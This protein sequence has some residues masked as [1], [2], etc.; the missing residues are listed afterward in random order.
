MGGASADDSVKQ[1]WMQAAGGAG[2]ST[3]PQRTIDAEDVCGIC[4]EEM[5]EA[6][7]LKWCQSCGKSLHTMCLKKVSPLPSFPPPAPPHTRAS[8][9]VPSLV[10]C[11][12]DICFFSPPKYR[13]YK[14]N[15]VPLS[16]PYCR[17]PFEKVKAEGGVLNLAA[18]S[19]AHRGGVDLADLY[20]DTHG[21]I[22]KRRR[23]HW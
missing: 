12:T 23:R 2:T 5:C 22:R 6:H 16:C 10:W 19:T 7:S 17:Q 21:F 3:T 15:E 14:K 1:A 11:W 18:H 20:P 9:F 4:F 8:S 13:D